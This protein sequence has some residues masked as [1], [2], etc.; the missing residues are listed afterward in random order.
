[1]EIQLIDKQSDLKLNGWLIKRL[2]KFVLKSLGQGESVELS[3][4][5]VDEEEMEDLNLEYRDIEKPTDVLSFPLYDD[6][7]NSNSNRPLILG[8]V[9]IC[10]SV[11][12]RNALESGIDFLKEI[13]LLVVHGILHLLGYDHETEEE[14]DIMESKEAEILKTYY[15]GDLT[16]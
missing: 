1:M 2:A 10:P 16:T 8:D 13:D 5:L 3:L 6:F 4:V 14:A 9:I 15:G 11:A 7:S 12:K